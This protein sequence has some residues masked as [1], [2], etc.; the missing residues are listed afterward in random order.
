L[1]SSIPYQVSEVE[2]DKLE[3][4]HLKTIQ[5][6]NS[7]KINE[8]VSQ[9]KIFTLIYIE[10]NNAWHIRGIT[11]DSK[12]I[13][14]EIN[15]LRDKLDLPKGWTLMAPFWINIAIMKCRIG[16]KK[17]FIHNLVG[18]LA[19]QINMFLDFIFQ[20]LSQIME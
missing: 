19:I 6:L 8:G 11:S 2:I 13:D 17:Q 4:R 9:D 20:W 7:T 16:L 14:C 12:Q 15:E 5:D 18:Y 10:E 3:I 1:Q